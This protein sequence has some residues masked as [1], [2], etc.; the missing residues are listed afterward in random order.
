MWIAAW[1]RLCT[2]P[3]QRL[4]RHRNDLTEVGFP[5]AEAELTVR[6]SHFRRIRFRG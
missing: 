6:I 4:V 5:I 1:S 2:S 3:L